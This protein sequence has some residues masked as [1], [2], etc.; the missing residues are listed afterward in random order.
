MS[1]AGETILAAD[2]IRVV[3]FRR[4]D[5]FAHRIETYDPVVDAWRDALQ[6][7][8]GDADEAWPP[9]P[10]LQQLHVE[11]RPTGDVVLLVGMA[12]RTHW[13]VAV[14]ASADRRGLI[15]DAAARVQSAPQRLGSRY[16][17]CDVSSGIDIESPPTRQA[18]LCGDGVNGEQHEAGPKPVD[19]VPTT[20]TWRYE[21]RTIS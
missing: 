1:D 15:F 12:G 17:R 21:I 6:S 3:F 10:P 18:V 7:A 13:S 11:R 4:G 20:T 5:R 9:S 2:G 14:E 8:E 19:R 16:V